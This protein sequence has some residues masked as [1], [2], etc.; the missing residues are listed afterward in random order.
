MEGVSKWRQS[1]QI[2]GVSLSSLVDFKATIAQEKQEIL[3]G[4]PN[5][6]RN[7]EETPKNKGVQLRAQKDKAEK[8]LQEVQWDPAKLKA[9]ADLYEK[10]V[11]QSNW[12]NQH[13]DEECLID[14]EK[15]NWDRE[16]ED[17]YKLEDNEKDY[18]PVDP[19]EIERENKRKRWVENIQ[20]TII[21]EE[22]ESNKRSERRILLNQIISE[23]QE[24][25]SKVASLQ[26]ERSKKIE[27][28][29]AQIQKQVEA[30]KLRKIALEK[31]KQVDAAA[32]EKK[33]IES[34]EREKK[35]LKLKK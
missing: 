26:D 35:K 2:T 15:K 8:D 34:E 16:D 31:D 17:R 24:G 13:E 7:T 28:R 21:E 22:N 1:K 27:E 23:T 20:Q 33:N 11:S 12:S 3:S 18:L 19:E 10:K 30:Q 6:I 32:N 29:K 5:I 25:R 4:R 14:F 9:K